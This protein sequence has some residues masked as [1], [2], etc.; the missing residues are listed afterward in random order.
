MEDVARG[1]NVSR[2][3][4]SIVFRDLPGASPE[5]RERVRAVAQRIG[6]RP[7]IRARLLSRRETR[8]LGVTFGVGHEF[9][10]D[11][12][13]GLYSAAAAEGYELVLSGVT[14]DR[15]ETQAVHELQSLRCDA[16][17]LLGPAMRSTDLRALGHSSPTV[18]VAR[19]VSAGVDVV[20]TDDLTA[21]RTATQHLLDLGHSRIVHVDGG[22]A[23]GARERR[24]GYLEAMHQAGL[25]REA[26]IQPGGL[27]WQDGRQAAERLV[28]SQ[29]HQFSTASVVFNDQSAVGY[30][31]ALR[32]AGIDVPENHS[33]VGFDNS[34]IAE[35]PWAQL[36][37][38][39][40][41]T[42][43]ITRAAV[44]R[45]ITHLRESTPNR[46]SLVPAQLIIRNSTA[47]RH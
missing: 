24:R 34:R 21:A 19:A 26:L 1:A 37:T 5:T 12:V 20:R 13:V 30:I 46:T 38:M 45:A 3:L 42:E 47:P 14:P 22:K 43:A 16:L 7:D 35:S 44:T 27:T 28:T 39:S 36:T 17:I 11:L 6:Y 41:D 25:A 9:H 32:H 10:A 29:A 4:V 18:A 2:A 33:V 23:P 8:L 40:Q 31:A 15:S